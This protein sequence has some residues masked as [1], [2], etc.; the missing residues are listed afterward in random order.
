MN[1]ILLVLLA[2]AGCHDV[3]GGD[4]DLVLRGGTIIDGTGAPGVKGDIAISGDRVAASLGNHAEFLG[5]M[6]RTEMLA[7]FFVHDGGET[8]SWRIKRHA[9]RDDGQRDATGKRQASRHA[10]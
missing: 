4:Y 6:T 2:L 3:Q 7:T 9:E 1:R 10:G 5:V 8:Q